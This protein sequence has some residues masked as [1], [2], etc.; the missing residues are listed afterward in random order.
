M[1][2]S[3]PERPSEET[4]SSTVASLSPSVR[5]HLGQNLRAVYADTLAAPIDQRLEALVKQLGKSKP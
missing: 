1:T 5:R 3:Y 4:A 2:K